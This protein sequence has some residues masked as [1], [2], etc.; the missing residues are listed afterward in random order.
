MT[1]SQNLI[2]AAAY[3]EMALE[4]PGVT[5][6]WDCRFEA[7]CILEDS[8]APVTLEVVRDGI[9]WSVNSSSALQTLQGDLEWTRATPPFDTTH[10]CG[11]IGYGKPRLNSRNISQVDV[12]AVLARCW[13]TIHK[14]EIYEDIQVFAQF[15][16]ESVLSPLRSSVSNAKFL[17]SSA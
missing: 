15:G 1:L 5:Q 11:K 9:S 2:P 12:A 7:A 8:V 4:F 6:V 14:D 13:R 10:A 3:L 17:G 16:D